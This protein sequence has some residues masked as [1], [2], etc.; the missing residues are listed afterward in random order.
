M[1]RQRHHIKCEYFLPTWVRIN[2]NLWR[3]LRLV[4]V[5]VINNAMFRM[6][7]IVS[8]FALHFE[9][10]A[11]FLL[12]FVFLFLVR[13]CLY[14]WWMVRLSIIWFVLFTSIDVIIIGS[15]EQHIQAATYTRTKLETNIQCPGYI[16]IY[17]HFYVYWC[18]FCDLILFFFFIQWNY[19]FMFFSRYDLQ[20]NPLK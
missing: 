8:S 9:L 14:V 20:R 17:G 16:H 2:L 1:H 3:Y 18:I 19:N 15:Y 6:K 11:W 12:V 10:I 13:V 4:T 7:R 5:V